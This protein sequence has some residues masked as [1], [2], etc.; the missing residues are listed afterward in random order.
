MKGDPHAPMP[1]LTHCGICQSQRL[2]IYSDITADPNTEDQDHPD[3]LMA[4]CMTCG[5]HYIELLGWLDAEYL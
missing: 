5:S 2:H 3:P 4:V 1:P